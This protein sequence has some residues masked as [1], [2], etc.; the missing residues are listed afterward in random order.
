MDNDLKILK[1]GQSGKGILIEHDAGFISPNEPRN[2]PFIN[3]IKKLDSGKVIIEEPLVVYVILQKY[4]VLNRN[5]RVYPEA[6]LKKQN[7]LYQKMIKERAAV[8][9]C[10]PAGTEIFTTS[11]WKNIEDVNVNDEIFT[12]NV[13]TNKL[14]KQ[15]VLNTIKKPYNDDMIHIYNNSTL[16]MMITKKHKVVLWDRNNKPYILTGEELYQKIQ[17]N[18]SIVSH[19]YIKNSAVWA[20]DNSEYF[21]IPNS[22]IRIKTKDW[23]AF[24]GLFIAEGHTS[25]SK[26][27]YQKNLVCITQKKEQTK[28][29]VIDLLNKLPF[30]YTITD[31]RQFNIYDKD[32]FNHL[33]ILGNSNTKFIPDYAKNWSVELLTEL[34]DWMLIGDGKNRKNRKGELIKEYITISNRLKDDVFEVMLKIGNGGSYSTIIPKDRYITDEKIIEKEIDYCNG[35]ELIKET[36]KVKRLIK[37]ENS[38]PLHIIHQKTTKGISL[39]LRFIKSELV[40]FN[41]DVYCVT[42]PNNTWL[43]RYNG[44]ISWT[45]N[46]DHPD[47]SIIAADRIS[48]NILETWWEG[49]TLMG[50]MEIL[51][52]PGF[53]NYGI[54]STKG[55]EVANLLRNRIKIGVSSRGVGSLKEGKNGEQIVQDDFEIICWD[56]VTA[57]S[58]PDA[59][60]FKNI[61][62]AQPYVESYQAKNEIIKEDIKNS[63]D[64]F[65]LS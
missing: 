7:D 33:N 37:A 1:R 60:M 18:D 35:L 2:L 51:M 22:N 39:D 43:M 8:G 17:D 64:N 10:V 6:V 41:D 32:L 50:K 42:V 59:W 12:M 20:G 38:K 14:E 55:D 45:H 31:D 62:E 57:P 56:V 40:P 9:E 24:L 3:E 44:K 36:I 27:G 47:T 5:G 23:A 4:G 19:S 13:N 61:E 46:C 48:H 26:G 53:I 30:K 58:T 15:F 63:L 34:L 28:K 52:S 11:G 54:V 16:D 25:G 49:K 29:L 65:L 21:T